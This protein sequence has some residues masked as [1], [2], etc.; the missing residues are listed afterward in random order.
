MTWISY[1]NPAHSG[2]AA[3]SLSLYENE[4]ML[5]PLGLSGFIDPDGDAVVAY[6]DNS[7]RW[8]TIP[9]GVKATIRGTHFETISDTNVAVPPNVTGKPR[10]DLGVLRLRRGVSEPGAG[11]E[12]TISPYVITGVAADNPSTPSPVRNLLVESNGFWDLPFRTVRAAL[13]TAAVAETDSFDAH[14]FVSGSGY[15]GTSKAQPPVEEGVI[16]RETDSK[17]TY[18]GADGK[19]KM[20]D[21]SVGPVDMNLPAGWSAP[22]GWYFTRDRDTVTMSMALQRTGIALNDANTVT[23]TG[24]PGNL[25]PVRTAAGTYHCSNPDHSS[26][27]LVTALGEILLGADQSHPIAQ[28][29]TCY[30]N[31]S[32]QAKPL[33]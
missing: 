3:P 32:W 8:I 24:L 23:F 29:S 5:A 9:A 13:G 1:P 14:W 15:V 22:L 2:G 20:T 21:Y 4:Q 11:D 25:R 12:Y 26:H 10:R 33:A 28:N 16:F 17:I 7:G 31:M 6:S 30:S 27:I 18:V 19:W